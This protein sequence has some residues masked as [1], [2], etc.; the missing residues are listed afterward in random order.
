MTRRY[1]G[2]REVTGGAFNDGVAIALK[3]PQ[4]ARISQEHET[5][6][7]RQKTTEGIPGRL[8]ANIP[9]G[10]RKSRGKVQRAKGKKKK[11]FVFGKAIRSRATL[12]I[13]GILSGQRGGEMMISPICIESI[14]CTFAWP[15]T[16]F[17]CE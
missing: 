15:Q 1:Q 13:R 11:G 16:D 6:L 9:Q 7:K 14:F 8:T 3:G 12:G 10:K 4:R 5:M 17:P 2:E